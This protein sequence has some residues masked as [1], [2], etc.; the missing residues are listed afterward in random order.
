MLPLLCDLKRKNE[1]KKTEKYER[2]IIINNKIG[3]PEKCYYF[4]HF[5]NIFKLLLVS[6]PPFFFNVVKQWWKDD[7]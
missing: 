2:L 6:T 7:L 5:E 1:R 3:F 4:S